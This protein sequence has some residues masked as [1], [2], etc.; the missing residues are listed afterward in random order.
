[1]RKSRQPPGCAKVSVIAVVKVREAAG[2]HSKFSSSHFGAPPRRLG[3][4]VPMK[5]RMASS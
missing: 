5:A 2:R 3:N 1:M 4:T